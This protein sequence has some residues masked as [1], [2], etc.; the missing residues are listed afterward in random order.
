MAKIFNAKYWESLNNFLGK[1]DAEFDLEHVA[2]YCRVMGADQCEFKI[3]LFNKYYRF[4]LFSN[5]LL[6]IRDKDLNF[7][8]S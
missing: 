8:S 5:N 7:L 3:E 6:V 1:I 2:Q 4:F